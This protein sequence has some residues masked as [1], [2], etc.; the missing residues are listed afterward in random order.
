MN[1]RIGV[2]GGGLAGITAALR[3]TDAGHDVILFEGRSGLGGLTHSFRRGPLSVDNGQ[4]VF[5]RCCTAYRGLLDRLGVSDLVTI[6]PRLDIGVRMPGQGPA[7]LRRSGLPAP[8]HL[9]GSLLRYSALQPTD[10]LRAV[11]AALA[12][13]AVKLDDDAIDELS[14]GE[15]LGR[16]GQNR[17]TVAALWD[18][19]TVATLNAPAAEASLALA[20][21][22]FQTG[23]LTD[24]RAGDIGW[25]RVP[26]QRLHG[27]AA[28]SS[29]AAAGA[30]VRT[31]AKVESLEARAGDWVIRERHGEEHAVDQLVLAVPPGQ[32]EKLLPP[33]SV[34][35]A[36]GWSQRLGSSPIVNVHI[37]F[38]RVVLDEPFVAG[39]HTP[40][41]WVFDRTEQ[42]G[43]AEGQ[44]IAISLSAA[45]GSIE[46]STAQL[47]E[48]LLPALGALLPEARRA[49]VVDFFATRERAATIR[50][51]P[52]TARSR[53]PAATGLPG[54]AL[55]GAWTATG[56][57]A[58]MESAVLSGSAAADAVTGRPVSEWQKGSV[59]V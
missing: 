26:L 9:A 3:C 46:R 14:F 12:L 35:L 48:W 58:T 1:Q 25:S 56:W 2:I 34:H 53:P 38:D 51:S 16:H 44:Y 36:P 4:H 8:L 31:R 21:K 24:A 20:T 50:P 6:Q 27:D 54:L 17:R 5:L 15:W 33:G 37:V 45:H 40:V 23:L 43:L 29:L 41:Q 39:V 42:S 28:I 13:R 30:T 52:G 7:R 18:L 47:R 32:A 11:R 59:P 49:Q 55:A 22:V 19:F 10:R 57:P